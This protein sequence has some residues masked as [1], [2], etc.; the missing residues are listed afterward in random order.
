MYSTEEGE[1]RRSPSAL[2]ESTNTV[3]SCSKQPK[4][5]RA[6]MNR[7]RMTRLLE[8]DKPLALFISWKLRRCCLSRNSSRKA[9]VPHDWREASGSDGVN[10]EDIVSFDFFLFLEGLSG[11]LKGVREGFR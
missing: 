3:S 10:K 6:G 2:R 5:D 8:G 4:N 7:S 11:Q 1:K 9:L